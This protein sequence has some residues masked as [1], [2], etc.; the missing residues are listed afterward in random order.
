MDTEKSEKLK[1]KK[2]GGAELQREKKK[3]RLAEEAKKCQNLNSM[4][5]KEKQEASSSNSPL[6]EDQNF[7]PTSKSKSLLVIKNLTV[8]SLLKQRIILRGNGSHIVLSKMHYSTRYVW[9]L[10]KQRIPVF[11]LIVCLTGSTYTNELMNITI[12]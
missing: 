9:R 7:E 11:L 1:T 10:A 8:K 4:F 2:K 12:L 5:L 3:K 6:R